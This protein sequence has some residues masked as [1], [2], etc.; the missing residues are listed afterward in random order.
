[1][2]SN[3]LKEIMTTHNL[4]EDFVEM[5]FALTKLFNRGNY[6]LHASYL[7]IDPVKKK[8]ME[9][10][11]VHFTGERYTARIPI[12][13]V[14]SSVENDWN[15]LLKY[16]VA[17]KKCPT[18]DSRIIATAKENFLSKNYDIKFIIQV[19]NIYYSECTPDEYQFKKSLWNYVLTDMEKDYQS[20]LANN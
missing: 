16:T 15:D 19:V 13:N 20:F 10:H 3:Q 6:S 7:S 5:Y 8:A 11:I 4:E 18:G 14:L 9:D 2:Y 12:L 1:M 17:K